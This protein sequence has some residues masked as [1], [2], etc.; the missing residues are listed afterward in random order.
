MNNKPPEL[1]DTVMAHVRKTIDDNSLIS[2]GDRILC[3]FSGGKDST[4]LFDILLLLRDI[5]S[6]ELFCFH[7]DH[8]TRDGASHEDALF[9]TA[10]CE[11]KNIPLNICV[12]AIE[13]G[14]SFEQRARQARY[15]AMT[16]SAE[17]F[18]CNKI[19]TAHTRDDTIE[20]LIMRIFSGTS[21]HGMCS[22]PVRRDKIIRPLI[23]V[24]SDAVISYCNF[25]DLHYVSDISN[26]D[27]KYRRNM[28][29]HEL[30]PVLKKIFPAAEN[31]LQ[32]LIDHCIKAESFI[33]KN[34]E[35]PPITKIHGGICFDADR[36]PADR[37][38]FC[39]LFAKAI[40]DNT[41]E[42]VSIGMLEE[43]YKKYIN[44]KRSFLQLYSSP[45]LLVEHGR[46]EGK[47]RICIRKRENEDDIAPLY[48]SI[49]FFHNN[50]LTFNGINN[51]IM[52]RVGMAMTDFGTNDDTSCRIRASDRKGILVLRQ[53]MEG[54]HI[55]YKGH[56]RS[57]KKIYINEKLSP[58]EKREAVI[59]E[60]NGEV[61][62]LILHHLGRK[63]YI[64]DDFTA[65]K[66]YEK[67]VLAIHCT[68]NISDRLT[69]ADHRTTD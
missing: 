55:V 51:S 53:R 47:N 36:L 20:T 11:K 54:D 15:A 3:A 45:Y 44:K 63:D 59:A 60:Q 24:S 33:E 64:A 31:S 34:I 32:H 13:S 23:N 68:K 42:Y 19:A 26:A 35:Y 65:Q 58:L 56:H 5:Y 62:A 8:C 37:F 57:L 43:I 46:I 18:N 38:E 67:K 17:R 40:R 69:I 10:V 25:K 22:I 49:D 7:M 1:L 66:D 28:I 30:V 48:Q 50:A 29:R 39:T 9:V 14:A 61:A 2:G 41:N 21:I 16:R 6:F 27:T 4:A 52:V 12:E